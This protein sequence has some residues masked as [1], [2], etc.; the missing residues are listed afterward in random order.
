MKARVATAALLALCGCTPPSMEPASVTPPQSC[1]RQILGSAE[2]QALKF[3]LPPFEFGSLPGQ[4]KLADPTMATPEE[5]KLVLSLHQKYLVPCRQEAIIRLGAMPEIVAILVESFARSDA[6][7]LKL[8]ERKMSW[9]EYNKEVHALR[10]D[11]RSRLA[12]AEQQA[13]G[14]PERLAQDARRRQAAMVALESWKRQQQVLVQKQRLLN[15]G[16]PARLNDCTYVGTTVS[17]SAL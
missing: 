3:K 13:N 5:A 17:C 14:G 4:A 2:H 11:T 7:Y 6:S 16:D 10:V 9:G 1:Y 8:V 12:A 15:P